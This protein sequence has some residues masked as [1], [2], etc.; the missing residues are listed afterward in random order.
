MI[1]VVLF[2][3]ARALEC[4]KFN[5]QPS[6]VNACATKMG[7]VISFNSLGC[8]TGYECSLE[9]MLANL[10]TDSVY[11]CQSVS[12]P[13]SLQSAA[14][15]GRLPDKDLVSGGYTKECTTA[16]DCLLQD[17]SSAECACGIN[18]KAYCRPDFS[19]SLF[20]DY[21]QSCKFLGGML[22]QTDLSKYMRMLYRLYPILSGPVEGASGVFKELT[23]FSLL[24]LSALSESDANDT[25]SNL[26]GSST[27][28]D[29]DPNS[30]DEAFPNNSEDSDANSGG[31]TDSKGD[32]E[33]T[34]SGSSEE[35]DTSG[36]TNTNSNGGA[37]QGS[38][39]GN[40]TTESQGESGS[41]SNSGDGTVSG[42]PVTPGPSNPTNDNPSSKTS[43]SIDNQTTSN[44]S[45]DSDSS[46]SQTD[47]QD[48]S[49]EQPGEINPTTSDT[50]SRDIDSEEMD[51]DPSSDSAENDE[52]EAE[53]SDDGAGVLQLFVVVVFCF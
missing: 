9:S 14:C 39:T 4:I 45:T 32:S 5:Q 52:E 42:G 29:I 22:E 28:A 26:R 7:A 8:F 34:S 25:P 16:A 12:E 51:L 23:E 27:R 47:N 41:S 33:G 31:F 3:L 17:G 44:N 13:T 35:A 15:D 19:S 37:D 50:D 46:S 30:F 49:L 1:C 20:E 2:T 24:E 43:T 11:M 48:S 10:N 36:E 21:W 18:G 40:T 38:D 53:S 6:Q